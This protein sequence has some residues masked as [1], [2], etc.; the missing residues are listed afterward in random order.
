MI[1]DLTSRLIRRACTHEQKGRLPG[2]IPDVYGNKECVLFMNPHDGSYYITYRNT[3][4]SVSRYEHHLARAVHYL[5]VMRQSAV[6]ALHALIRENTN[7]D[8]E[9]IMVHR[10]TAQPAI[11]YDVL[12]DDELFVFS[13]DDMVYVCAVGLDDDESY[14]VL[15][16]RPATPEE[17]KLVDIIQ[18]L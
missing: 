12:E 11:L 1:D 17:L 5:R 9:V 6:S 7:D 15:P 16:V 10:D 3:T 13:R 18:E 14:R 4:Y 8:T 2:I